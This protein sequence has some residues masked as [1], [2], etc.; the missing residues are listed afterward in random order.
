M[1]SPTMISRTPA[2]KTRGL[3]RAAG[4]AVGADVVD[5]GEVAELAEAGEQRD[6]SR[7][8]RGGRGVTRRVTP[9]GE[10]LDPAQREPGRDRGG[11][12]DAE[13]DEQDVGRG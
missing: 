11:D 8:A 12:R 2:R 6:D 7:Q 9:S 13:R 3:G 5:V 10:M 4:V 1:T